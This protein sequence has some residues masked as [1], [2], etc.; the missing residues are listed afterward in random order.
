MFRRA[1]TVFVVAVLLSYLWELG[2][3]SLYVG[4]A[5]DP[6]AFWHC[7]VASLVDGVMTLT[8]YG[9]GCLLF[10][11]SDWLARADAG[12]LGFILLTGLMVGLAGEWIGLRVLHRWSYTTAMPLITSLGL[13]LVPVLQMMLI[14]LVV[15]GLVRAL[16]QS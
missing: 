16:H 7:F 14:P 11:R 15:F 10:R 6:K 2:Q 8:I 13:G 9:A 5:D 12:R 3:R 4:M 1:L